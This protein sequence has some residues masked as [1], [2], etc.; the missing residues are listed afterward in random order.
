MALTVVLGHFPAPL[1]R[2][3]LSNPY[4]RLLIHNCFCGP[5]AVIVFFVVSG[6]CIHYPQRRGR[7]L[8][9][10][11]SFY[12]RRYIRILIPVA[13]AMA[14]AATVHYRLR[15]FNGSILWSL[16]CEEIYYA[17]YPG[18]LRM[19]RRLARGPRL[20]RGS[21]WLIMVGVAY[22]LALMLVLS[23]GAG[24]GEYPVYPDW[25]EWVL[26]LP[27]W[28]LGC[29]MAER[30]DSWGGKP[31]GFRQY[32]GI[33]AWRF[34][35]W[36]ASVLMSVLRFHSWLTYP[37]TLDI[38]A[39]LAFAWLERE[40]FEA[41]DRDTTQRSMFDR[42]GHMSFSL[43]LMHLPMAIL[44][45]TMFGL[46]TSVPE[47]MRMLG[48]VLVATWVFYRAVEQPSHNVARSLAM[49]IARR[50]PPVAPVATS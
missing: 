37:W 9:D 32:G 12:A 30:Y 11:R 18:L 10:I 35:V 5:A 3:Y 22:L 38:F 27:C 15:M 43:Y 49:A 45:R 29:L 46:E 4:L 20:T 48:F 14:V 36:S 47:F 8:S 25:L 23:Q 39:L 33:W 42:G 19:S 2:D 28:L 6:F 13:V 44:Y 40:L 16:V 26:G 24:N 7:P 31:F 17:L 41:K 50:Y 1:G 34:I 21:E